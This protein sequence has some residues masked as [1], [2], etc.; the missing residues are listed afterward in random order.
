[1]KIIE[2][3]IL[4][5]KTNRVKWPMHLHFIESNTIKTISDYEIQHKGNERTDDYR[6]GVMGIKRWNNPNMDSF[7]ITRND[8]GRF[9]I[10]QTMNFLIA[11]AEV[12]RS[13]E[14]VDNKMIDNW[15]DKVSLKQIN[16]ELRLATENCFAQ[17]ASVPTGVL[18]QVKEKFRSALGFVTAEK[19]KRYE[20]ENK[21]VDAPI[22]TFY[23]NQDSDIESFMCSVSV[24][25]EFTGPSASHLT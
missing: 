16:L 9:R 10:A 3:A 7:T 11:S 23:L 25:E 13:L 5:N 19:S 24:L 20:Q 1:M 8:S 21:P 6:I 17:C 14:V 18:K 2:K 12:A 15:G 4:K 22:T